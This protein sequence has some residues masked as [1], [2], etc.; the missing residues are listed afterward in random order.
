MPSKLTTGASS[1]TLRPDRFGCP[2]STM[3]DWP[4]WAVGGTGGGRVPVVQP[5]SRIDETVLFNPIAESAG[6][7]P[8]QSVTQRA[9]K[10]AALQS[11]QL[12]PWMTTDDAR[13]LKPTL[14]RSDTDCV[15]V[16][17]RPP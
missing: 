11:C 5:R 13:S 6:E 9:R 2:Y 16:K 7:S 4:P 14:A 3:R 1:V 17:R 15:A 10:Y 8:L 12:P